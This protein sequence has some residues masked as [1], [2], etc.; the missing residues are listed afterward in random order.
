MD[1]VSETVNL[2]LSEAAR[3]MGSCSAWI[4]LVAVIEF[5]GEG[6]LCC[7]SYWVDQS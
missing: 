1:Q 5:H 6:S 4:G 3:G 7:K 2:V